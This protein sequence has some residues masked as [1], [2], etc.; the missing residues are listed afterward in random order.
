MAELILAKDKTE[1]A[2]AVEPL[3]DYAN[4]IKNSQPDEWTASTITSF[5]FY[6]ATK[7]LEKSEAIIE[8]TSNSRN[9][10]ASYNGMV[11][12]DYRQS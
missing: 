7:Q 3:V 4:S 10:D 1:V 2:S 12:L 5:V 9:V 6:A 11:L 8:N